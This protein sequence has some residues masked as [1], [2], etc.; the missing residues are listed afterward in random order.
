LQLVIILLKDNIL[1]FSH[2]FE[3]LVQI[4][5]VVGL[6]LWTDIEGIF[7]KADG[8]GGEQP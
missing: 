5:S 8:G 4:F 1:I 7:R 3:I 6:W 2:S